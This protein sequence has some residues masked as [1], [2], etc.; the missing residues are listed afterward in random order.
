MLCRRDSNRRRARG[1]R[2]TDQRSRGRRERLPQWPRNAT[3]TGFTLWARNA[4]RHPLG[5]ILTPL[6]FAALEIPI[7]GP[8]SLTLSGATF[9]VCFP[10]CCNSFPNSSRRRSA[11]PYLSNS[12][13]RCDSTHASG[14][15]VQR[16][17]SRRGS[18]RP[19]LAAR[20]GKSR[21]RTRPRLAAR[22]AGRSCS[23]LRIASRGPRWPR[24]PRQ[25]R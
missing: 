20:Y 10:A 21:R 17:A 5:G 12:N 23:L 1:G 4:H 8:G 22:A 14:Q 19:R 6:D 15:T 3:V 25:P 11:Q 9:G 7:L 13:C 16:D 18:P 2:G 24:W